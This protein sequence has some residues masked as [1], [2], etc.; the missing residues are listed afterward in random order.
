MT[1][2][3]RLQAPPLSARV[4]AET[5]ASALAKLIASG[6]AT[7]KADLARTTGLARSTVDTGLRALFD[8]GALRIQ[9]LR[10]VSGRGRPAETLEIDPA[11]GVVVVIECELRGTRIRAYDLGQN[12]LDEC[13]VD[14]AISAGP[15]AVLDAVVRSTRALLAPFESS[16]RHRTTVVSVPGPVDYRAG[17]VFRPPIMPGW[18]G[19]A[20]VDHLRSRL[21]GFVLLENDV[22]VR[23]LGEARAA[24]AGV[25]PLLYVTIGAGIGC[26]IVTG[27]GRLLRGADGAAGDIGHLTVRGE[28]APCDC[29]NRGCL[30]AVA[31]A[32]AL[33][34]ASSDRV[35]SGPD[36]VSRFTALV[37][38]R[39]ASCTALA[40]SAAAMIGESLSMLVHFYNPSRIV[41]GGE[42]AEATDEILAI[43]RGVVY[44][45]ALP[46]ATRN[47]SIGP[48]VL[49][50][51]A[52]F[53]GGLVLGLEHSFD[54]EALGEMLTSRA[55]AA[56]L[57]AVTPLRFPESSAGLRFGA[58]SVR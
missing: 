27:D 8:L 29:G 44:R 11:F 45:R 57:G 7:T 25:G 30:E 39:D 19:F 31:S 15:E 33:A 16:V 14:L 21:G 5:I 9:G 58:R 37:A 10:A 43:V 22:N 42:L 52:G 2:N 12:L 26:G 23:A 49:G 36:A 24:D 13:T 40:E 46:L 17:S 56:Q 51:D 20:V 53:A 50:D 28:T 3:L 1:M 4:N 47:L 38:T 18:D 35:G 34:R 54:E 41:V 48:S 6:A 55:R 32:G